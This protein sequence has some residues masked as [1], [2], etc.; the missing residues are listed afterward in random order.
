[1]ALTEEQRNLIKTLKAIGLTNENPKYITI[2][3]EVWQK[4]VSQSEIDYY[5][6]Y[7]LL[8]STDSNWFD[9]L[10]KTLRSEEEFTISTNDIEEL[11]IFFRT[12]NTQDG[13]Q[14]RE[15]FAH[16]N[17]HSSSNS[18]PIFALGSKQMLDVVNGITLYAGKIII[19]ALSHQTPLV[20]LCSLYGCSDI[21]SLP[22]LDLLLIP[23]NYKEKYLTKYSGIIIKNV[24]FKDWFLDRGTDNPGAFFVMTYIAS[25][26]VS[27]SLNKDN[28][29][30]SKLQV[31]NMSDPFTYN[32]NIDDISSYIA[33]FKS[34]FDKIFSG[35]QAFKD[36]L[37][38]VKEE[39][40]MSDFAKKAFIA[41]CPTIYDMIF[42][43]ISITQGE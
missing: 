40:K 41:V 39:D 15:S 13:N 28:E 29:S 26:M 5:N 24:K 8:Q 1:M 25:S 7:N 35:N 43:Y 16:I 38:I 4:E 42:K 23:K 37:N 6:D 19:N 31:K 30:F 11:D 27:A 22:A 21:Y 33:D 34:F 2:P 10:S 9:S 20:N 32:F 17:F 36:L 12:R 3:D 14:Y 18:E